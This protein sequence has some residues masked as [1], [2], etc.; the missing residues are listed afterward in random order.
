RG[1][2]P[3]PKFA[4]GGEGK[5]PAVGFL[6]KLGK[7]IPGNPDYRKKVGWSYRELG[8][9]VCNLAGRCGGGE[10]VI[11]L[12]LEVWERVAGGLSA[13]PDYKYALAR[14]YMGM[15]AILLGQH[16]QG[17]ETLLRKGLDIAEKLVAECPTVPEYGRILAGVQESIGRTFL[18]LS[19][20]PEKA[21]PWFDK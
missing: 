12:A 9:W 7:E 11:R 10:G 6:G 1:L 8:G 5:N 15:S 21:L 3:D 19:K 18:D 2:L 17:A 20:E 13:V 14:A 4:E 16:N